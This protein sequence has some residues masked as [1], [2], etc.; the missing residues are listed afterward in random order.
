M[1]LKLLRQRFKSDD[2]S[3]YSERLKALERVFGELRRRR[4]EE[5]IKRLRTRVA[6]DEMSELFKDHL[7]TAGRERLL[8]ILRKRGSS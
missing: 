8:R 7:S 3:G 1:V 6:G 2:V 5:Y 4:S